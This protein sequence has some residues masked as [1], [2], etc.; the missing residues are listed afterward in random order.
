MKQGARGEAQVHVDVPP[1]VVYGVVS[2]VK[3]MGEWSPET[4]KCD[5]IEGAAGPLV[6][7]V[8]RERT[9]VVS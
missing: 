3:R 8:S 7:A 9:S 6:G 1:Q 4:I 5:W 2:D